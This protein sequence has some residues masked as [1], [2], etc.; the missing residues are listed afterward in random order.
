MKLTA[1]AHRASEE[2]LKAQAVTANVHWD[3]QEVDR[4]FP[5]H[6]NPNLE[7]N[8]A[9]KD[10]INSTALVRTVDAYQWYN[11]QIFRLLAAKD[12]QA[13]ADF[14]EGVSLASSDIRRIVLGED[15]IVVTAEK[16]SLRDAAVRK[17]LHKTLGL[18]EEAEMTIMVEMRNCVSHH[19]ARD[20]RGLVAEW[21]KSGPSPWKLKNSISIE[22]EFIRF[23]DSATMIACSIGQAQISIFDQM[24]ASKFGLEK[25]DAI[26]PSFKRAKKG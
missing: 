9:A 13:F 3:M 5:E 22:G 19:L 17:H 21:I 7:F 15:A 2:M 1:I 6:E 26:R 18:W 14:S 4:K 12:R 23:G 16:V 24:V 8:R 25:I 10:Y 20:F 11:A